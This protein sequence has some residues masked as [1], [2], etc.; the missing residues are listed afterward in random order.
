MA[1]IGV[2]LGISGMYLLM[3]A[4]FLSAVQITV[5]I[6]GIV[7]LIVY[8]VM[9]VSDIKQPKFLDGSSW[10]KA[11]AT[12]LAAGLFA[13]IMAALSSFNFETLPVEQQR[14]STIN[15]IGKALLSPGE[16]GFVLA[17]ELIS[18]LLI[19]AVIGAVTIAY[20]GDK[21]S[22]EKENEAF[23]EIKK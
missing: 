12:L 5:Y 17:F 1:L 4:Q 2:L 22:I 13:L 16:K 10:R 3:D 14:S 7:V 8:V 23:Q 20:Q 19:A 21:E 6:G 15:E 11:T 9:L 18:I